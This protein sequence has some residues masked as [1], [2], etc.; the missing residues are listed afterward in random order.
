MFLQIEVHFFERTH[1]FLRTTKY[2]LNTYALFRVKMP[3]DPYSGR[4]APLTS[5]RFILYIYPKI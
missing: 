2:I 3:K 1:Y 4:T 5:K